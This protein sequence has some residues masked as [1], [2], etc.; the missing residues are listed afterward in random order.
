M[1][2]VFYS[3]LTCNQIKDNNKQLVPGHCLWTLDTGT[4]CHGNWQGK[5]YIAY[6]SHCWECLEK[7]EQE[8]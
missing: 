7:V 5:Q 3:I 1:K 8:I 2:K 4:K 6:N